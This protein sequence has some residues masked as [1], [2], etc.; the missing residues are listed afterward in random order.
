MWSSDEESD[1]EDGQVYED[2]EMINRDDSIMKHQDFQWVPLDK[3]GREVL[4]VRKLM[5][6]QELM[7]MKR[8]NPTLTRAKANK[9]RYYCKDS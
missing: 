1:G 3:A 6:Y 5:I 4:D 7:N 2:I 8:A 9:V